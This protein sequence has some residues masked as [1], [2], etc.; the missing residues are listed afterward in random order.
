MINPSEQAT[1]LAGERK[2]DHR[3]GRSA[4]RNDTIRPATGTL[5]RAERFEPRADVVVY[6]G[7]CQF[8]LAS[9]PDNTIQLVFTSPPYNIGKSY[10]QRKSLD[11][12]LAD[13]RETIAEV[14]RAVR[15]GG[16]ICWQVGNHVLKGEIVPLD[17]ALYPIFREF[18]L[19]LRNRVVWHYEHGLHAYR[20]LSGRHETI[21][22]FTKGDDYKFDLD[23]IRV[24]QKY[25]NKRHFKGPKTG[26]LSSNPKGKNPG[27]VWII[28][29]VKW[30]HVEKTEH[31]CQFPVE[32]VERF[33]LATTQPG[34]WVL[35]PYGGVGSAVIAAVLNGRRGA[36]A[37]VVP[38]YLATAHYRL[39]LAETGLLRTRPMDRPV[40][41][42][43]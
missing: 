2:R 8:L 41:E 23:G 7:P 13:Q 10:E 21:L 20:R 14:V 16:S 22:W 19:K 6:P 5:V 34:D 40:Y 18:G 33:V 27:D 24:P 39:G 37:E 35:D 1:F 3:S 26:E 25:P 29:N 11:D 31:P 12:Y 15:P 9:I 43:R 36:M 28:P 38:D 4:P 32:L 17:I 30:N 42:P